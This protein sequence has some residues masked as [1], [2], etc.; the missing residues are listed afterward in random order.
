MAE[1]S[2]VIAFKGL[3][4]EG[5][6]GVGKSTLID[7]LIRRHTLSVEPRKIRTLVHL[8][9]SHTYGPLARPE[10]AGTLTVAENQQHLERIVGTM[11]WLHACVQEKQHNRPWCFVIVDALHLT[12][13]VRPGIVQWDDVATF[14]RRLAALEFKLLFLQAAPDT[15]HER[16]IK[17]RMDQQFIREY[18]RKFGGNDQEI[19]QHFV[20]EQDRLA[21]LFEQ[22]VM[23]KRTL[24]HDLPGEST[25][26]EAYRFWADAGTPQT[27]AQTA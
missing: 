27:R 3:L 24:R 26:E 5:T 23:P 21:R 25:V 20:R 16:G 15:I 7:A 13:C 17:P 22:S 11:E 19:H 10:D 18:A 9:Q 12:H 4:V 8:A 14:D 1:E 2:P 6:S